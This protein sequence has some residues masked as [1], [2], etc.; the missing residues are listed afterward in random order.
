MADLFARL[1][2]R[3]IVQWAV[4]YVAAAWVVLQVL[5]LAS[6]SYG[7]PKAVMHIAFGV[8]AVGFVVTLVLAWYHGERGEQRVRGMELLIVA[9]ILAVGGGLLW[10]FGKAG[11]SP[12]VA[13]R[14]PDGAQRYPGDSAQRIPGNAAP[15]SVAFAP[16]SPDTAAEAA[17]SGLHAAQPIP[18]KSI[19]VLPFE[20][21]SNDK[22]NDYF[23]AGMQDLILTKLADI[24]G[25]KVISRTSTEQYRSHPRNLRTIA[26][27][28]GVAT[29]L[30]GSVQKAGDQVLINVQLIDAANDQH[31]W[32]QSYQRTLDN[33]FGVEGDVAEKIAAAL[34]TKL[35]PDVNQR[36]VTALSSD[37]TAND[38]FLRAEYFA[39]RGQINT[40]T[41][42]WKQAIPLYHQA[43]Q[44][45]PDF[46]LA[47]ARL[48]YV[49]SN[50]AWFGGG[51]ENVQQLRTDAQTQAER[52]LAL[53]PDL[54]EAH[55]AIGFSDYW[56][57]SDYAGALTAFAA[58][59]KARPNDAG[60]LEARG[61][62]LRRQGNFD[63]AIEALQ[64]AL[65]RDPRNTELSFEL[66]V[67]YMMISRYTE[68]AAA[69]QHAL[70]LDPG[71]I[72][73]KFQYSQTILFAS[74][75]VARAL[76]A[77]QGDD[78]QLQLQRVSLLEYQREYRAAATL[79]ASISDT[80]DNFSFLNGPKS[81]QQGDLQR[82]L[83]DAA[84][85]GALYAKALPLARAQLEAQAGLAINEATAWRS[86]ADAELGLGHVAAGLAA[87]ARSREFLTRSDDRVYGSGL[88][89]SN[90]GLYARANRPDLAVPLLAQAL[91][92]PGIGF[93]YSPVLLWIDPAWD[94][95]RGDPGFRALLK[96]YAK[97]KPAT[98]AA[99]APV[100]R[101]S[102]VV[103]GD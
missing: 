39:N 47:R 22:N 91:A 54:P 88:M 56:G 2:Q 68:A 11:S 97:Y 52:A 69:L 90:A 49:E 65:A 16:K 62:V 64:Q 72:N 30:E 101:A 12:A 20:N 46:A 76:S 95:I 9:L 61:F 83:G 45:A 36:L 21:L 99:R 41:A 82:L 50:L 29:L 5:D 67:T 35:S 38:L 98:A 70:A 23:V 71:N 40:D 63:T 31:I 86:V 59:L 13:M 26:G 1:K 85:A 28:L 87:I 74:G 34:K 102:A 81:L 60:A 37:R 94:P 44:H 4:A 51:G 66:G 89:E 79:L 15:G 19:A 24:G 100:A 32:A 75:D 53:Q 10:H 84:R 8:L 25:L 6:G 17:A 96:Q 92:T 80:A 93:N 33:V 73:A 18:A 77:A 3:K 14:S 7:W 43:I 57:R 103:N 48:S 42:A 27:Q 78:P 58:A 55:L